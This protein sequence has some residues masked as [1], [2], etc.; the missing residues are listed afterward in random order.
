[1]VLSDLAK[2][3]VTRPGV[4]V[5][6]V[7]AEERDKFQ[8]LLSMA[9]QL[10]TDVAAFMSDVLYFNPSHLKVRNYF[11]FLVGVDEHRPDGLPMGSAWFSCRAPTVRISSICVGWTRGKRRS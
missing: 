10:S 7:P 6:E 4:R 1:M 11:A 3:I 2:P 5:V 8:A 9:F